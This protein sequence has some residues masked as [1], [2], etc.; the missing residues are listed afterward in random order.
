MVKLQRS[1][2]VGVLLAGA[3]SEAEYGISD[4]PEAV[5]DTALPPVEET[6]PETTPPVDTAVPEAVGAPDIVVDP[7]SINFGAVPMDEVREAIFTISNVGDGPLMLGEPTLDVGHD[8]FTLDAPSLVTLDPGMS[9][10]AFVEYLPVTG[11]DVGLVLVPSDDPDTPVVEVDLR[12]ALEEPEIPTAVCGVSPTTV[13]AIHET[14][15]WL[16][17]GSSDPDGRPLTYAWRLVSVPPGALPS[18]P[19]GAPTDPNRPGFRPDLVGLYTAELVVTND[20]G[21]SSEPCETTLEA[22]P[23]A[24]L[25]VE[26]FWEHSGDDMDLHMVRGGGSL[27]SA[28]DC[29]YANCRSGLSWGPGGP[30][31][32]PTLDIDDIGGRGPENINI[33]VPEDLTYQVIVHD[34]PGSRHTGGNDVTVRIYLGGVLEW[35]DTRTISGEDTYTGFAEIDWSTR[36]VTSL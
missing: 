10:D 35:E 4:K 23:A 24:D 22:I 5:G 16:G 29:Y 21:V 7:V 17:T 20:L 33:E 6:T 34:Y 14:A 19:A 25:W 28:Q 13:E 1:I 9:V 26:M 36:V 12:G 27:E 18:M 3:C 32:D 30:A 31:G 8:A 15:T 2:L 11:A